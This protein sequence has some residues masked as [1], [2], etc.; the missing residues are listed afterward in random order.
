M[1]NA[2]DCMVVITK[3]LFADLYGKLVLY[4]KLISHSLW[5]LYNSKSLGSIS[6]LSDWLMAHSCECEALVLNVLVSF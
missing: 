6:L 3:S 2:F 1:F 4:G 5:E